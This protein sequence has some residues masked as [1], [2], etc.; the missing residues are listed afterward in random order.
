MDKK[1]PKIT[2]STIYKF[3]VER[4][5]L[6]KK[7]SCMENLA[8]VRAEMSVQKGNIQQSVEDK[9]VQTEYTRTL[10]KGYRFFKD[11]HVQDLKCHPM[12]HMSDFDCVASTVLPSMKRDSVY[13]VNI[14]VQKSPCLVNTAY[15]TCPAGLS[16][17]CNHVIATLYSME[18]YIH[19]GLQDEEKK[20]CTERLQV[21]NQPTLRNVVGR[22]TDEVKLTKKV[23]GVEKRPKQLTI[24]KWDC[25]PISRR[26]I[27]PNK[28]RCLRQRLCAIQEEKLEAA[29]KAVY[30]AGTVSELKKAVQ[31][32]SLINVYGTSGYLQLLDDEA[33]PLESREEL[34]RKEREERFKKRMIR[35]VCQ[36]L[37]RIFI[38][39]KLRCTY[40]SFLGVTLLFGLL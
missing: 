39:F 9:Y 3:S 15:C 20:G 6:R 27:D 33:A 5:V 24:N 16:G 38:R 36:C 30:S 18:D 10:D 31:A 26:I 8:D 1:L 35:C 17:C 37:T 22:P 12:P 2:F 23:Y 28:A 4:K 40:L 14:V 32:K 13:H 29:D 19:Q 11:G 7:V 34:L 21:W 25:R